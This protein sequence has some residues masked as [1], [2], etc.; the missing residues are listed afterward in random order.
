MTITRLNIRSFLPKVAKR[1]FFSTCYNAR[2]APY[3]DIPQEEK[4]P[5]PA[6]ALL[7]RLLNRLLKQKICPKNNLHTKRLPASSTVTFMD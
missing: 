7:N 3:D 1:T 4:S 6:S 2:H 5:S